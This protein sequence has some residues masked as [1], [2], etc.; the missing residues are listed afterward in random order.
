MSTLAGAFNG[1]IAYGIAKNLN[2]AN[3]WL[4]WRWIFL[5]E[6]ILPIG[7][8]ALVLI[9]LPASPETLRFGFSKTEKELAIQRSR[10]THNTS[11]SRLEVK[12]VPLVLLSLHFWLFV[13]IYCASHFCLSSISNFL[14]AIIHV[15]PPF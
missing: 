14:P 3:G 5:I 2:G 10:E 12:K 15:G 13:I 8:S 9:F 11:E 7:F 1:L 6:G 4:A